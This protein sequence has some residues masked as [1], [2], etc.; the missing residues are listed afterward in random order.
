MGAAHLFATCALSG[1]GLALCLLPG[2][3]ASRLAPQ[4]APSAALTLRLGL[5]LLGTLALG[6]AH[7][8]WFLLLHEA[9][10][11]TLFRS[12]RANAWTQAL[13]G[14]LSGIPGR[15]WRRVHAL[16]HRWTGWQDKDPT[17]ARLAQA[18]PR[19]AQAWVLNLAWALWLPL[20]ALLYRRPFWAG[21]AGSRTE[22]AERIERWAVALAWLCALS[23]ACLVPSLGAWRLLP[24]L[25]LGLSLQE[26]LS[27][28]QHS[29]LPQE[30][31][32][33]AR[34]RPH[35]AADQPRYTRSL[36]VPRWA[37]WLL[38]GAEAHGLHHMLPQVPGPRLRH[39]AHLELP[40][41][42]PALRWLRAAKALP[43]T[44]YLFGATS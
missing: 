10:H 3:L 22:R 36:L 17:T 9:G 43:V 6:L 5:G 34:V 40:H 38:L 31:A 12:R 39:L 14:A 41:R 16:H 33:A 32:G 18:P 1:A 29:Q 24:G 25:A 37:S 23:V 19:G 21:R 27:L 30:R 15:S 26:L 28:S 13:A 8:G 42:V 44:R 11:H 2:D 35:P 7:L 4:L 20:F